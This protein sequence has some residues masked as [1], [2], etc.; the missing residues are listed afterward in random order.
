MIGDSEAA[1][2]SMT[3]SLAQNFGNRVAEILEKISTWGAISNIED[4]MEL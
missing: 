2:K 3:T 4:M 1:L